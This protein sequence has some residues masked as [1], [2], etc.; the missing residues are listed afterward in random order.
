MDILVIGAFVATGAMLVGRAP[1]ARAPVQA[2]PVAPSATPRNSL[3]VQDWDA[4]RVRI[5]MSEAE[6][7]H[8]RGRSQIKAPHALYYSQ[9]TALEAFLLDRSTR[10]VKGISTWRL[11]NSRGL[12]IQ[13]GEPVTV[14][15]PLGLPASVGDYP[16]DGFW[17]YPSQRL[18]LEVRGQRIQAIYL[19]DFTE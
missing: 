9:G 13:K 1:H 10:R 3:T 15:E 14:L 8:L 18:Q 7:I 17:L 11:K 4:G 16:G 19:A 2:T 6:V 12:L 5:G